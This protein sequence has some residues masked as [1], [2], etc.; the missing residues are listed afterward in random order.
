M[1]FF[2]LGSAPLALAPLCPLIWEEL[3]K[4]VKWLAALF[5]CP[6][7][8]EEYV[9]EFSDLKSGS[10]AAFLTSD[11][12][13]LGCSIILIH[14]D[15]SK[16]VFQGNDRQGRQW[17]RFGLASSGGH[18]PPLWELTW[19]RKLHV[20]PESAG[21]TTLSQPPRHSKWKLGWLLG[22]TPALIEH[23]ESMPDMR[24]FLSSL[25]HLMPTLGPIPLNVQRLA[26]PLHIQVSSTYTDDA[27]VPRYS[28]RASSESSSDNGE[29]AGRRPKFMIT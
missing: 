29:S 13:G 12:T 15:S 11:V 20:F 17:V 14:S 16:K 27:T 4:A 21:L 2:F 18:N 5:C 9:P 3:R 23:Q 28:V 19:A 8:I 25:S 7:C 22:S 26:V 10:L 24:A 6:Q 1:P